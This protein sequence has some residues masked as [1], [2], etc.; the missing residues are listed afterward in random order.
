M[1]R[2]ARILL[3]AIF[4]LGLAACG[5]GG[6]GGAGDGSLTVTAPGGFEFEPEEATAQAGEVTIEFA[7]EDSQRH[8]FV[9]DDPS[10]S[11]DA[12]GD[13]SDSGTVTLEPGTYEFY[14]DVPGHREGGMEGTLEVE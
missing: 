11:L 6:G 3:V 5:G 9:I 13:G 1:H 4:A 7:N 12:Q 8:T 14:C 10:I 2:Y